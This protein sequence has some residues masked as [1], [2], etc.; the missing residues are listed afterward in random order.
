MPQKQNPVAPSAMVALAHQA[1]GLLA[2]LNGA[3]LHRQQR[4][5]AAWFTEWLVLPQTILCAASALTHL[6]SLTEQMSPNRAAMAAT[7]N[8]TGGLILAEALS[9]ELAKTMPRPEAQAA[10]KSLCQAARKEGRPLS[11]VTR[12]AHPEIDA[13]FF[14]AKA[15][16]GAA[17]AEARAFAMAVATREV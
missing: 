1:D 15:H 13:A 7:L 5:G 14:D 3:A 11:E 9:F 16:L 12:G 8:S 2:T 4:D 17:P 6:Q 10:A